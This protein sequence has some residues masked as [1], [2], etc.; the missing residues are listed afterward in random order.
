M[1]ARP[2]SWLLRAIALGLC[3]WGLAE[4]AVA[5]AVLLGLV[6]PPEGWRNG[7]VAVWYAALWGPFWTIGGLLYRRAAAA[8]GDQP[9]GHASTSPAPRRAWRARRDSNP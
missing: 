6:D 3:G 4:G 1:G 8:L 2:G 5:L 9:A 7:S